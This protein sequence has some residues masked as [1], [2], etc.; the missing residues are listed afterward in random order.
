MFRL[1][2]IVIA[3]SITTVINGIVT[4]ISW[5]RRRT[6][7]GLYFALG[8]TGVTLWT[9]AATFDYAVNLL[10]LKILFSKIE[11]VGYHAAFAFFAVFSIHFA[12]NEQWLEKKWL[13]Y[14][15]ILIPT[16]NILL[17]V[18]NEWHGW[19]WS[20]FIPLSDGI[21]AFEYGPAFDWLIIDSYALIVFIFFNAWMISRK[22]SDLI[23]KQARIL[24]LALLFPVAINLLYR[25]GAWGIRGVDWTSITFSI[26]SLL[27]V[28]ALYGI[29]LL[30]IVP[31]ARDKLINNLSDAMIV[32][33]LK[34][35]IVDINR[36]AANA[37]EA[38]VDSLLGRD[39]IEVAPM[40]R[41]FL[42]QQPEREMKGEFFT[43]SVLERYFDVL[44]SPVRDGSQKLIGR[45]IIA[46]D[47]TERKRNEMRLLQLTQAVEQSPVSV[48]IT[49]P[50]GI[51][52][53]VNPRF[54]ALT[55]FS[56]ED[57]K[58]KT[59][60]IVKSDHMP[61]ST[62]EGLWS[63]IKSGKTWRGE[64]LN[65]K[66]NGEL[67]WELEVIS[68]VFDHAGNI[69]NFIAVKEDVTARK[70]ADARL[71]EVNHQLEEKLKEI[72]GLQVILREQ[73]IRDPLT[74]LY[75]RHF[76]NDALVRELPRAQREGYGICF[77][78]MDLDGFK[79]VNDTYGHAAGD[80]TIQYFANLLKRLTRVGDIVCRYGGEEFL[81]VLPNTQTPFAA[82]IAERLRSDFE[83]SGISYAG[84][85]IKVTTS[86]GIS[87]F[88]SDGDSAQKVLSA[89]DMALYAAK[90]RG[91]NQVVI[92]TEPS[93]Q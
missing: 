79:K 62:F 63:S 72:E 19:I 24:M 68:P 87:E 81:L 11:A 30:D 89:A 33:D 16:T 4:F 48:V 21:Y 14:L 27:F 45:L 55:G 56:M 88:P 75:N 29:K 52:T 60:R 92:W 50:D 85:H 23:K 40:A 73:A 82:Q 12:G 9:F 66:K 36:E 69:I 42:D 18:T 34:N 86:C 8:M 71:L 26:S 15:L 37:L 1:S 57:V 70:E 74:G 41:S 91:R 58:G 76:L 28:Y 35:R 25:L 90:D 17:T 5:E 46:R 31:I 10:D 7:Y 78:L 54:L 32:V 43:G 22:G 38:S 80:V 51:I 44:I 39:L 77:I 13:R 67:Y 2:F 84:F 64:L 3:L 47:I 65:K 83:N 49:D 53:Y 59:P 20:E 93:P 6:R 61:D